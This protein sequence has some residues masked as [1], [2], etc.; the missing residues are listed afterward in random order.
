MFLHWT[1]FL[2]RKVMMTLVITV[3]IRSDSI[4]QRKLVPGIHIICNGGRENE[5]DLKSCP[6]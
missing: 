6:V 2:V 5:L 3:K 1:F 4:L